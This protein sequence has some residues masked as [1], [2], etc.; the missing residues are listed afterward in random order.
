MTEREGGREGGRERERER[1]NL[2]SITW[3]LSLGKHLVTLIFE[4]QLHTP[5]LSILK[6]LCISLE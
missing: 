1:E 5:W 2:S 4:G 3:N 6:Y